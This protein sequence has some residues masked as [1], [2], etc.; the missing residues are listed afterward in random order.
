MRSLA[1]L[2]VATLPFAA[3][4]QENPAAGPVESTVHRHLG[5]FFRADIGVGY[6]HSSSSWSDGPQPPVS[7][8]S[9][10]IGLAVGGAIAEDWILAGEVWGLAGPQN[11]NPP[12]KGLLMWGYAVAVVHYFMPA[13]VY[14]SASPGITRLMFVTGNTSVSSD[15]GPGV[16]VALGKEWWVGDH[17]GLG[18]AAELLLTFNKDGG[19]PRT[20]VAPGLTFSATFN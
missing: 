19:A 10:P 11:V 15:W 7:S 5:F 6:V 13:N 17:W 18:I 2:M 14:L 20:T 1:V 4:A 3:L 12:G 9:I 8:V 16:K